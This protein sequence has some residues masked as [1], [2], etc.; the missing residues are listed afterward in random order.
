MLPLSYIW[1]RKEFHFRIIHVSKL[2]IAIE[3]KWNT[4]KTRVNSGNKIC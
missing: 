4:S 3:L 1:N 2:I